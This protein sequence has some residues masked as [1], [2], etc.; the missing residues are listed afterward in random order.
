M[1]VVLPVDGVLNDRKVPFNISLNTEVEILEYINYADGIPKWKK[2][3][4][5]C[6]EFGVD[7][8]KT[9]TLRE[10]NNSITIR[11][12]DGFGNFAEKNVSIFIDS[13]DPKIKKVSP[14]SGF[15]DGS[16][17]VEFQELNPD[18]LVLRYGNESE[19]RTR[20]VDI[21]IECVAIGLIST[22]PIVVDLSDFDEQEITYF[23]NL[24][25]IAGNNDF[26]KPE[27]LDIDMTAPFLTE[28]IQLELV[29]NKATFKFNIS[30]K[31][32]DRV[33]YIDEADEKGKVKNLCTKLK[34]GICQRKVNFK[35]GQ[36][37]ITF[38][39]I[40]EAE[41]MIGAGVEFFVDSKEPKIKKAE[42]KKGLTN[43]YFNV[44]FEEVNPVDLFLNYIHD[45]DNRSKKIN[46]S[47]CEQD[48]K[49]TICSD[50]F[51]NLT[52]FDGWEIEYWFNITDIYDQYD[53]SKR[54][55]LEVDVTPPEIHSFDYSIDNHKVEFEMIITDPNFDKTEYSDQN[56]TN[57]KFKTLCS[58]LD[59][60][61]CEKKV[62]FSVGIHTLDIR[63]LDEA[64][65]LAIVVEGL[66]VDIV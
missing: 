14:K 42:P 41:N 28:L 19:K 59:D 16:F 51:V 18:T 7:K 2:L 5:D 24:T 37:N 33:T 43:G 27:D 6:D 32:F 10:G 23:F 38:K 29:G 56:A 52:D 30:E 46:I 15:S 57:P 61:T 66:E 8:V 20:I 65:N 11:A 39:I 12:S 21:P 55:T 58:K 48:K 60:S 1:D 4:K 64:G 22:C 63:A 34:D 47:S 40:D 25:D 44:E 54:R 31:N 13:K 3:C 35:E 9:K 50:I 26:D 45:E 53:E 62:S 36:H 17:E 49:K